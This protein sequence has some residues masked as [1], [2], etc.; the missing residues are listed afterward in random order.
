MFLL[1][2]SSIDIPLP[3]GSDGGWP[4]EMELNLISWMAMKLGAARDSIKLSG[5]LELLLL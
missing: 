5:G 3:T 4:K 1:S 2:A